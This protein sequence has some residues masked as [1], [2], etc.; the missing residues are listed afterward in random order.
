MQHLGVELEKAKALGAKAVL[1]PRLAVHLHLKQHHWVLRGARLPDSGPER[2]IKTMARSFQ[3]WRLK[4]VERIAR[5]IWPQGGSLS[6]TMR[7]EQGDQIGRALEQPVE[8][9]IGFKSHPLT[10]ASP[11]HPD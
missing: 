11:P 4:T 9:V 8:P 10:P 7:Q 6:G 5:R 2:P 3:L 1:E